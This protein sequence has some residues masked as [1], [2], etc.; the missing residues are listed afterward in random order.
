[1]EDIYVNAPNKNSPRYKMGQIKWCV[2]T[3]RRFLIHPETL[4]LRGVYVDSVNSKDSINDIMDEITYPLMTIVQIADHVEM[5]SKIRLWD[6]SNALEMYQIIIE[7]LEASNDAWSRPTAIHKPPADRLKIYDRLAEAL[8]PLAV[9]YGGLDQTGD[10]V[11]RFIGKL[12]RNAAAAIKL[13]FTDS[14]ILGEVRKE[15]A[16]KYVYRSPLT[17]AVGRVKRYNSGG[18]NSWLTNQP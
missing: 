4:K 15:D 8:Y 18:L 11:D 12:N 1:M 16:P 17:D 14:P 9:Q 6:Q 7:Y 2:V 10:G 5:G 13:S 3:Q